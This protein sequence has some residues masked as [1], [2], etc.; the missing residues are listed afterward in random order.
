MRHFL[1]RRAGFRALWAGGTFLLTVAVASSRADLVLHWQFDE[2]TGTTAADSAPTLGPQGGDNAGTLQDFPSPTD[3]RWVT[4]KTGNALSFQGNGERVIDTFTSDYT[5]GDYTVAL[6]AR[7]TDPNQSQY[8]SVFATRPS[9]G[10]S[11]NTFQI[12]TDG[13][14]YYRFFTNNSGG[15]MSELSFGPVANDAWQHV[16]ATVEGRALTLYIDGL[17]TNSDTLASGEAVDFEAFVA[18]ANRNDSAFFQGT[19]DDVQ[20]YDEA[21]TASQ[22]AFLNDNPGQTIP[23]PTSFALL[24]LAGGALLRRRR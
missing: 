2:S 24:V 15:L 4:G 17:Q 22:I 20:F 6:W 7:T 10:G 16:A 5:P 9:G 19:V 23:E 3:A 13:S 1:D 14:G 12:D 11:D 18:G 8:N 21:L